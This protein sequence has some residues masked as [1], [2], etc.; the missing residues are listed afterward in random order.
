MVKDT[1][2]Q[3]G[4]LRHTKTYFYINNDTFKINMTYIVFFYHYKGNDRDDL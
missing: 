1:Q 2:K 3:T 4:G